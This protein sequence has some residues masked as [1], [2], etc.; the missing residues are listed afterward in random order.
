MSFQADQD[1]LISIKRQEALMSLN[2]VERLADAAMNVLTP[3]KAPPQQVQRHHQAA[4]PAGS[5]AAAVSGQ[6]DGSRWIAEARREI[7]READGRLEAV[8]QSFYETIQREQAAADVR[9]GQET[10]NLLGQVTAIKQQSA[11]D[12]AAATQEM[13]GMAA[14]RAQLLDHVGAQRAEMT[15]RAEAQR[16]EMAAV[17]EQHRAAEVAALEQ[18]RAAEAAALEQHRATTAA[19]HRAAEIAGQQRVAA[20]S[21][22]D[23]RVTDA[24]VQMRQ[25]MSAVVA[26]LQSESD[27][28]VGTANRAWQRQ[29]DELVEKVRGA[30]PALP[31][32]WGSSTPA[33]CRHELT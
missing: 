10:Q 1:S 32:C 19:A 24:V 20:E 2:E 6:P 21:D 7:Q 25:Q 31:S 11:A 8:Q 27:Q 28:K 26:K 17:L 18:H 5:A 9:L 12:V 29:T 13:A 4:G 30:V 15:H 3:S 16:A 23:R 14:E 22:A 33:A